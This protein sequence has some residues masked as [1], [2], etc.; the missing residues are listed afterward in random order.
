MVEAAPE[1][2]YDL[3]ADHEPIT[4]ELVLVD[5]D[6]ARRVRSSVSPR[7]SHVPDGTK[8]P[9][10]TP[11]EPLSPG[12]R[13]FRKRFIVAAAAF[14]LGTGALAT[15]WAVQVSGGENGASSGSPLPTPFGASAARGPT[16]AKRLL[17]CRPLRLFRRNSSGHHCRA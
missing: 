6:L 1:G 14:S 13:R 2:G 5:P 11:V 10:A 4:P 15:A 17:P 12:T 7:A 9:R 3:A 8:M 16:A